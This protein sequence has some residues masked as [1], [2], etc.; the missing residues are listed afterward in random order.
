MVYANELYN[1]MW[2]TPPQPPTAPGHAP[3]GTHQQQQEAKWGQAQTGHPVKEEP[4]NNIPLPELLNNSS[5][6]PQVQQ[7]GSP[8]S[9]HLGGY[10]SPGGT[11]TPSSSA[12]LAAAVAAGFSDVVF[13]SSNVSSVNN[14]DHLIYD[15]I[16]MSQVQNYTPSLSSSLGTCIFSLSSSLFECFVL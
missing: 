12:T 8:Q 4:K 14:Q 1:T 16:G 2:T 7:T 5:G 15:S 10:G 11:P 3:A 6:S 13:T 9:Q